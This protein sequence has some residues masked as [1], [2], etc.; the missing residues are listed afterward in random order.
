[1]GLTRF[2]DHFYQQERVQARAGALIVVGH[3]QQENGENP[4]EPTPKPQPRSTIPACP[5]ASADKQSPKGLI[6]LNSHF[7]A[8]KRLL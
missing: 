1:M 3:L 2:V 5:S 4:S 7:F 8:A 6:Y